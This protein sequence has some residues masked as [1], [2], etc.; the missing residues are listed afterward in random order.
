MTRWLARDDLLYDGEAVETE[1]EVDEGRSSSRATACGVHARARRGELRLR[2]AAERDRCRTDE[3]GTVAPFFHAVKALLVGGVLV[4]AGQLR[5][6][7][8]HGRRHRPRD[9]WR[10]GNG[11][12]RLPQ[13]DAVASEPPGDAR[14]NHDSRRRRRTPPRRGPARGLRL[15]PRGTCSSSR[16]LATTTPNCRRAV[17]PTT[18]LSLTGWTRLSGPTP[19]VMTP[20]KAPIEPRP[21]GIRW[22]N[23]V[24]ASAL[25]APACSQ[26]TSFAVR[27]SLA[28]P[29][30]TRCQ[31]ARGRP[32]A[33]SL[34]GPPF[35]RLP[36]C[37]R[38]VPPRS[39]V[40]W[41]SLPSIGAS[42]TVVLKFIE[43]QPPIRWTS[44]LSASAP[45]ELPREPGV[46]H[47]L[48]DDGRVLYVGKA[49]D[50]RSRVRSTPTRGR[51]ASGR[52]SAGPSTSTS[53]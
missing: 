35:T 52:W 26:P 8:R 30:F 48:A 38:V 19:P 40:S 47:F 9:D 12:R 16:W 31:P 1:V 36:A 6:P 25:S 13:P 21:A 23:F 33:R 4:A 17:T 41:P 11:S 49:V 43:R 22:R 50:L 29:P 14:R 15:E 46:Y 42:L 34:A 10:S 2:R 45:D 3:S 39:L 20:A 24:P 44:P 27:F 53:R 18:N 5:Q 28:G 51:P 37:S 7:R 32:P